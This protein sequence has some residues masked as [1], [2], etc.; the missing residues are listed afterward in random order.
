MPAPVAARRARLQ[1]PFALQP[2]SVSDPLRI[3]GVR[4]HVS[5][6]STYLKITTQGGV[7][8]WGEIRS[9]DSGLL[10]TLPKSLVGVSASAYTPIESKLPPALASG[11][12]MAML[13]CLGKH[14]KAPVYQVL[15][16]PT[17]FKVRAM[18]LVNDAA[19]VKRSY[20]LGHRAFSLSI[21][22]P[23]FPNSGKLYV[24]T[25]R[26]LFDAARAAAGP[27]S[28]FVLNC[29]AQLTAGDASQLAAE[30]ERSHLLWL[31]EPCRHGNTTALRKISDESVTPI[32]LGRQC[33]EAS[34]FQDLLREETVDILRPS[35]DHFSLARIRKIA[36][37][38][39]IYYIAVA[40]THSGGTLMTAAALH[41]A[42]SIPNFF[43]LHLPDRVPGDPVKGLDTTV[44]DGYINLPAASGLGVTVDLGGRA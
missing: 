20:A 42:A 7:D 13:D 21:P 28:D 36:A 18:A 30:F 38:A 27:G 33:R 23:P 15:G 16:G 12:C 2:A 8:G 14:C 39:E 11:A 31:D 35:L 25:I 29:N 10:D 41:L 32:G 6:T 43:I 3:T 40:P 44:R 26:T 19:E 22:A 37:L 5:G 24:N 34:D 9:T 17:R 1:M 4:T